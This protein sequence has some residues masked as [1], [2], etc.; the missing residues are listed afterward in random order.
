MCEKA[1]LLGELISRDAV[2][3][4]REIRTDACVPSKS[5]A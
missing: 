3:Y 5:R 4:L 2:N 1:I